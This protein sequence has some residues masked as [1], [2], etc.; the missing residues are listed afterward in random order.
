MSVNGELPPS[1]RITSVYVDQGRDNTDLIAKMRGSFGASP[2]DKPAHVLLHGPRASSKSTHILR[3][4]EDLAADLS[5][6]CTRFCSAWRLFLSEP[7]AWLRRFEFP[8]CIAGQDSLTMWK[9]FCRA[10]RASLPEHLSNTIAI[11]WKSPDD[12]LQWLR[13][14]DLLGQRVVL[15]CD[16]FSRLYAYPT[17]LQTEFLNT[18][19]T[20]RE[21]PW[22]N[23][24]GFVGVG[25]FA[26]LFCVGKTVKAS[27]FNVRHT[28]QVKMFDADQQEDFVQQ[29]Q[30]RLRVTVNPRSN[31]ISLP[32]PTV[33]LVCLLAVI[34]TWSAAFVPT[35]PLLCMSPSLS[36][37]KS[38]GKCLRLVMTLRNILPLAR[39]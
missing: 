17:K 20:A 9:A 15:L 38:V 27:P 25:T 23:L 18:L 6:R 1:T 10:L 19:R 30:R 13:H 5:P 39:W 14:A 2:L 11:D 12:F 16:E 36:G 4:R 22:R 24:Q 33:T 28:L 37:C 3:A 29:F 8:E 7:Y 35:G 21:G 31:V 34:T 32:S 26:L